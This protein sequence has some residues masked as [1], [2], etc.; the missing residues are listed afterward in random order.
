M[1]KPFTL[2][3]SILILVS[4]LSTLTTFTLANACTRVLYAKTGH[5]VLV[6]NNMDWFEEIKTNLLVYPRGMERDGRIS[7]NV[8]KWTSKY[9]SIVATAYE[10]ITTNGMNERG[11]AAHFLG[12]NGSDYGVRDEK[13]PGLSILLWAQFYLDNFQTVAQAVRFTQANPFQVVT[14]VD[15][16][17][18]KN[19]ELHLAL[20]DATGDSA[21][22]EYI[23]GKPRIYHG[24]KYTVLTNAPT[25]DQQLENLHQY[26]GYGGDKPLPGTTIPSDR[27]VRASFYLDRLP[28]P[29]STNESVLK[30]FSV[31][32]NAGQP[33][34]TNTPERAEDG[35]IYESLWRTVSDLTNHVYYFNSTMRFNIIWARLDKFNLQPGSPVMMLDVVNNTNLAGDVTKEFKPVV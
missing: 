14:Y 10:S 6:G 11:L 1:L 18:N 20:E 8:L 22:I 33:Y 17:I 34:G 3:K 23:D 21:I 25:Y 27:F 35:R 30:L 12:L 26:A 28:E 2:I 5:A 16:R 9:G 15:P 32:Q 4:I 13:T 31:L 29:V 24:H 7:G 19:L